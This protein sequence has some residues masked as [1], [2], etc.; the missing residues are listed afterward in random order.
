MK[1]TDLRDLIRM[2]RD[3]GVMQF[4]SPEA[5]FVLGPPPV[6]PAVRADAPAPKA[7][8]NADPLEKELFETGVSG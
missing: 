8:S 4:S 2:C 6:A 7:D 5:S 1:L 3:E